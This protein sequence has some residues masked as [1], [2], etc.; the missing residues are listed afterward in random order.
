MGWG[1]LISDYI[2]R[3]F[4]KFKR[5]SMSEVAWTAMFAQFKISIMSLKEE[6]CFCCFII[7]YSQKVL[8]GVHNSH[9]N[10]HEC[11]WCDW[12]EYPEQRLFDAKGE[13]HWVWTPLL[14]C[15]RI[16]SGQGAFVL[17]TMQTTVFSEESISWTL[18]LFCSHW[19]EFNPLT[20][21]SV[22]LQMFSC[23]SGNSDAWVIPQ[24][25]HTHTL[26]RIRTQISIHTHTHTRVFGYKLTRIKIQMN[27]HTLTYTYSDTNNHT[28]PHTFI[29]RYKNIHTHTHNSQ[30]H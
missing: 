19:Q 4:L 21:V 8:L 6:R 30:T 29:F 1:N 12:L 22:P 15:R 24:H 27:T 7:L 25:T 10:V 28:H 5:Y 9:T 14:R 26:T 16:Y 18:R 11:E 3:S 2:C 23:L 17:S 13:R 20:A